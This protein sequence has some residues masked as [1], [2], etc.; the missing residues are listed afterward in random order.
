V[1]R[2]GWV[3][4]R[5]GRWEGNKGQGRSAMGQRKCNRIPLNR[6]SVGNIPGSFS[7]GVGGGGV[8]WVR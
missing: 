4:E 3:Q 1:K 6:I 5:G 8:G 2:G 7:F